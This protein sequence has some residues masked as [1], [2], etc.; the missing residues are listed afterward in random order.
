MQLCCINTTFAIML[1]KIIVVGNGFFD[2]LSIVASV[3]CAIHCVLLPLM[4]TT[5][6]FFG[7]ELMEN[8]FLE[9]ATVI[10]S[11]AI[12]G[13]AIWKGYKKYHRNKLI[14]LSFVIGIAVL[15]ISNHSYAEFIEISLKFSG[16]TILIITHM[17]NLKKCKNCAVPSK[18]TNT[19]GEC[20]S[21]A[22]REI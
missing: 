5:L 12:G 20:H 2:R 16:A 3:A 13:L 1:Q 7:I 15:I 9:L 14:P 8:F 19:H 4:F 17:Y 6:P 11:L 18:H 22:W 10:I 21:P